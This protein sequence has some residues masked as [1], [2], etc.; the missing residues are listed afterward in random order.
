MV[1]RCLSRRPGHAVALMLAVAA[2]SGCGE[3]VEVPPG[4]V[5]KVS[6][7]QGLSED[8]VRP[9]KLR[10]SNLCLT[11][12]NLIL[13][14][15]SDEAVK[16][17][18]KVFIP[19]DR[20]NLDVD[21][22]GT[23]SLSDDKEVVN[24]VFRRITPEGDGR[25]TVIPLRKVYF[26]YAQP[27]IREAARSVLTQ[28][29]IMEIMENRDAISEAIRAAVDARL[30]RAPIKLLHLGLANIQPPEV[31]TRAQEAA[32]EREIAIR[33]AEAEK[34][35]ALK[36]AE[37]AYEVAVKQQQV[38]LKEAETQVLVNRK[39]AEGVNEAFIAQRS[40]KILEAMAASGN[41]VFF[42][43]PEV[44]EH[45]SLLIGLLNQEAMSRLPR[46][47]ARAA[48]KSEAQGR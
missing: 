28:H 12:D 11:C 45:P 3:V 40:L 8:V 1:E 9:S 34:Q 4:Y 31:I 37:A 6:T 44:L 33:Q 39:L 18:L 26:T 7:P 23:I 36:K 20:L 46:G 10:L 48:T 22:R 19:K 24:Q 13:L 25:V 5:G 29:S 32:K 21:L 35:V 16:E 43:T 27:V 14:Q 42:I 2:L 30:K 41:K 38:D 17:T 47:A 15:A